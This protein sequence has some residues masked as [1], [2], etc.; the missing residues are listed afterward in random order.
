MQSSFAILWLLG[1]L[2]SGFASSSSVD[3]YRIHEELGPLLS[4]NA[5][6]YTPSSPEWLNVTDHIDPGI[7]HPQYVASVVAGVEQDVELVIKFANHH[8]I[9]FLA[10][11]GGHGSWSDL[12]NVR[13]GIQ[14]YIRALNTIAIHEDNTATIGGGASVHEVLNGLAAEGKRSG[15]SRNCNA[16]CNMLTFL[17]HGICPCVSLLGPALGGGHGILQGRYGLAC[18]QIV[19]ANIVLAN[20]TAVVA[21]KDSHR[22]L[23]W[24]MR[25][26]GHNFG[27]VTSVRYRVYDIPRDAQWQHTLIY[28][29]KDKLEEALTVSNKL[30]DA[31]G[32]HPPE[33]M[34][35]W[36]NIA[37]VPSLDAVNV[38]GYPSCCLYLTA[39][40]IRSLFFDWTSSMKRYESI[41]PLSIQKVTETD[42]TKVPGLVGFTLEGYS[43]MRRSDSIMAS[44]SLHNYNVTTMK[45]AYDIFANLTSMPEFSGAYGLLESYATEGVKAV[46]ADSTAV[47]GE[48]RRANIL[49]GFELIHNTS[50]SNFERANA[51]A[52]EL[53]AVFKSGQDTEKY[54]PVG[55]YPNYARGAESPQ[56]LYGFEPWRLRR[57]RALKAAYDPF[58]R[59]GF[60]ASVLE[61][62]QLIEKFEDCACSRERTFIADVYEAG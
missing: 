56:E 33:L 45:K 30:T 44:V 2:F 41:G 18:D 38:R 59:F 22:E 53:T 62:L 52:A 32:N 24:A 20:G 46:A 58:N 16:I 43:C 8:N 49:L 61:P 40:K 12:S 31:P 3:P 26:A 42:Y 27:I 48:E 6:I 60:Y 15:W 35:E 50:R 10:H 29:N 5:A 34:V 47:S 57:L 37:H 23:Y 19:S 21:S 39:N 25:G 36:G 11:N 1:N 4:A 28:F 7:I 13:H 55:T 17:V 9:P 54:G 51:T 14:I